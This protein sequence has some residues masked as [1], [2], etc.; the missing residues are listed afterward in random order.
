MCQ[1]LRIRLF[2]VGRDQLLRMAR[3]DEL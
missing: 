3:P 2:L 1:T